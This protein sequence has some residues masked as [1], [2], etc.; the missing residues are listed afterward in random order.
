MN[1]VVLMVLLGMAFM[2]SGFFVFYQFELEVIGGILVLVGLF[3]GSVGSMAVFFLTES[4]EKQEI[5]HD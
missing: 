2:I 1:S 3:I 5:E 4:T